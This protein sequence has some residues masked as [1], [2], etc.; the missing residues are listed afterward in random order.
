MSN[1]ASFARGIRPGDLANSPPW[2]ERSAPPSDSGDGEGSVDGRMDAG[3]LQ[4][5]HVSEPYHPPDK[6]HRRAVRQHVMRNFH[7]QRRKK[8]VQPVKK[9]K[10]EKKDGEDAETQLSTRRRTNVSKEPIQTTDSSLDL[11]AISAVLRDGSPSIGSTDVCRTAPTSNSFNQEEYEQSILEEGNV[12]LSEDAIE[13]VEECDS[14]INTMCIPH[15]DV[16][17]FNIGN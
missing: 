15:I 12:L 1:S 10:L 14:I 5:L 4:F 2:R 11:S 7:D 16:Q 17:T 6:T 9:H 13:A 8:K 3:T